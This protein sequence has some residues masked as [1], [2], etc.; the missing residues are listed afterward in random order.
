MTEEQRAKKEARDKARA[1]REEAFWQKEKAAGEMY[2]RKIQAQ[3]AQRA[4]E[5]SE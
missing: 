2:Y 3:L 5:K 1:E 4:Q